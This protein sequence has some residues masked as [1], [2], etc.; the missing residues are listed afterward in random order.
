M[1]GE[2]W[3]VDRWS[4]EPKAI[5]IIRETAKTATIAETRWGKMEEVK[6]RTD[7][8]NIFATWEEAKAWMVKHA[9]EA[10]EYAKREVDRKRS[11]LEVIKAL[12]RKEP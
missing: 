5:K 4:R 8:R 2:C 3:E 10:L 12:K 7:N 1:I 6:I 11:E 9:E